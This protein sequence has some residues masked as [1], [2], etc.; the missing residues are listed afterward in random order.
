ME[1]PSSAASMLNFSCSNIH[2]LLEFFL[3][4]K[5][6]YPYFFPSTAP[7]L[8]QFYT[9]EYN[10][11]INIVP[12]RYKRERRQYVL[13]IGL[14]TVFWIF[15]HILSYL[16]DLFWSRMW[17]VLYIWQECVMNYWAKILPRFRPIAFSLV[18]FG[19]LLNLPEYFH[20]WTIGTIL[21][22]S[23]LPLY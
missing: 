13:E 19:L 8:F 1:L 3:E 18:H 21:H 11:W 9:S 2:L 12:L 10:V 17:I 4:H 14:F 16:G 7:C 20:W 6:L 22:I 23:Y 5:M 15:V